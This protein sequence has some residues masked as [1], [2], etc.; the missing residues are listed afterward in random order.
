MLSNVLIDFFI[1]IGYNNIEGS[2]IVFESMKYTSILLV[3][4]N[5]PQMAQSVPAPFVPDQ[6][7]LRQREKKG[8]PA[9]SAP[10]RFTKI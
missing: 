9:T 7:L 8:L 1:E 3:C 6:S 5:L 2:N 4:T 10:E